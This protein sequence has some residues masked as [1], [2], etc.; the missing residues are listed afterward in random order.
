MGTPVAPEGGEPRIYLHERLWPDSIQAALRIDAR[1]D[2]ACLS[3][4]PQVLGN[5]RLRQTQALP[6]VSHGS[7]G[8]AEQIQDRTSAWFGNDRKAGFHELYIP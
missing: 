6:E 5:R 1:L 8:G 4:H 3:K 7:L 2:E